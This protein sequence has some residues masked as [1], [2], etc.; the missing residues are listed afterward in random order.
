MTVSRPHRLGIIVA[1]IWGGIVTLSPQFAIALLIVGLLVAFSLY[2]PIAALA[3]TLVIS[4]LRTLFATE[5]NI[6]LPLDIGLLLLLAF[7]GSYFAHRILHRQA[8]VPQRVSVIFVPFAI[9]LLIFGFNIFVATASSFWFNEWLKWLIMLVLVV[10]ILHSFNEKNWWWLPVLLAAAIIANALVGLYIFLG[11]S[12][13]DHL[14]ILGRF[15]R[16]F[17]TFGQPNP[18]GGFMGLHL[19][20]FVALSFSGLLNLLV[21]WRRQRKLSIQHLISTGIFG[22]ASGLALIAIIASWSRGAW[23]GVIA[24]MGAFFFLLP[25]KHWQRIFLTGIGLLVLGGAWFGGFVPQSVIARVT[26]STEDFF[27][28]E[29]VRGV[30]I[31]S[32]NY[33]VVER[34]AHWQAALNMTRTDPWLGVGLGNYE[35]VYDEYRL[36]NWSEALGHAHNYYLNILGETGLIGL[37]AYVLFWGWIV[38]L[39]WR[40]K[41]HPDFTVRIVAAGLIGCWV[42][43]AVHSLFDNLFVNNLFLHLG[44]LLGLLTLLYRSTTQSITVRTI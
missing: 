4:P 9:V 25:D 5:A 26:S 16:A 19:P 35:V 39:T 28:F 10:L 30:D 22:L 31:T 6:A 34:L 27:A 36:Q 1:L 42:Y 44:C 7:L 2:S 14:L 13:A 33:A 23:L 12:G 11:G 15:Y 8:V 41:T 20:L 17:G 43:F 21:S 18:F 24:S 32:E 38:I 37:I 29:D 3:S 40:I